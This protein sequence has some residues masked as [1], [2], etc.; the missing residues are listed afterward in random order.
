MMTIKEINTL[1]ICGALLLIDLFGVW[2][3]L[4]DKMKEK[5]IK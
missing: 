1:I 5:S 2:L 3:I 4:A